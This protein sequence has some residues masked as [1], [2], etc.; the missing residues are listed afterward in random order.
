[1]MENFLQDSAKAELFKFL[2]DKIACVASPNVVIVTKEYDAV[3]NHIINLAGVSS[4]S[5]KEADT[6]IFVH[7]RHGKEAGT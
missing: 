4:C 7:V 3:S 2:V 5:H 6:Q 1:M